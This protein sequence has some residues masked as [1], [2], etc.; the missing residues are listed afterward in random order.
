MDSMNYYFEDD[1][2]KDRTLT[3]LVRTI[4]GELNNLQSEA[5]PTVSEDAVAAMDQGLPLT[6][7][8]ATA[9]TQ[10]APGQEGYTEILDKLNAVV[11]QQRD[12]AVLNSGP[13][14]ER[15][16]THNLQSVIK[17]TYSALTDVADLLLKQ[18]PT[19]N[20]A[21]ATSTS[22][23]STPVK[24]DPKSLTN[25]LVSMDNASSAAR[26]SRFGRP[27][28]DYMSSV[29]KTGPETA[30]KNFAAELAARDNQNVMSR[31]PS[32]SKYSNAAAPS[33]ISSPPAVTSTGSSF[34][35][36]PYRELVERKHPGLDYAHAEV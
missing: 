34:Q 33:D 20:S 16:K 21:V 11:K 6:K 7:E 25:T 18:P 35:T 9:L 2:T 36:I 17:Q 10:M 31:S 8:L 4:S 23:S 13:V 26:L 24:I 22:I 29:G 30:K 28:G 1:P 19:N 5:A 32:G 27:N 15:V 14:D 12:V 3:E